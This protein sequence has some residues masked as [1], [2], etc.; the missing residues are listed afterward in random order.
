MKTRYLLIPAFAAMLTLHASAATLVDWDFS[1]IIDA[2]QPAAT[3]VVTTVN[4]GTLLG[5]S[6]GNA[7]TGLSTSDL[8][9]GGTLQYSDGND[10]D[11]ELNLK[12]W[13]GT[14]S[15]GGPAANGESDGWM[16][17]TLTAGAGNT[18]S[19]TGLSI[20]SWRNGNAAPDDMQFFV[21]V[22]GGGLTQFGTTQLDSGSGD[23]TFET[24]SFTDTITGA[25]EI[26]IRFAPVGPSE[27]NARGDGNLHING[28]TV[29]GSVA[30][31][32]EPSSMALVALAMGGLFMRRRR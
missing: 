29:T 31:I 26:E 12:E 3:T 25:S 8:L 10:A 4:S 30:P 16:Q 28:L 15:S 14:G 19:L 1:G 9:G 6:L 7:A 23:G 20:S 13:D 27:E 5:S 24:Y 2:N 18:I 21:N 17:F 11:G 22:D 32:P